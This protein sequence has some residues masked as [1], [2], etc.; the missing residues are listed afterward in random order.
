MVALNGDV[1]T[2]FQLDAVKDG[3]PSKLDPRTREAA[4]NQL[5]QGLGYEAVRGFVDSLRKAAKIEIAE[6]RLP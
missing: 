2:L 1:Y 6:N 5:R 4:L 3:D